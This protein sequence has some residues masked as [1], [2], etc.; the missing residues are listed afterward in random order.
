MLTDL[1]KKTLEH[2][3]RTLVRTTLLEH[4]FESL[5]ACHTPRQGESVPP[6]QAHT[7][8]PTTPTDGNRDRVK[9]PATIPQQASKARA[10]QGS[11][12]EH[13]KR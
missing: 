1:P 12:G 6:I 11:E 9:T 4:L 2:L 7:N 8:K 5:K 13:I 3:F 10:C